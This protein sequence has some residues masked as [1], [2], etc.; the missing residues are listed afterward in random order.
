MQKNRIVYVVVNEK[1][2]CTTTEQYL[3]ISPSLRRL[4]ALMYGKKGFWIERHI[5]I[6]NLKE[7]CEVLITWAAGSSPEVIGEM[8]KRVFPKL[9]EWDDNGRLFMC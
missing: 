9:Q 3:T 5:T 8:K 4:L 6:K 2:E 7:L 1:G